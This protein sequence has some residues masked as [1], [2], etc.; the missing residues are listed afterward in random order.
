MGTHAV[1]IAAVMKPDINGLTTME[2][3]IPTT[4][5]ERHSP[6]LKAV[7]RGPKNNSQYGNDR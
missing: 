6:S 3:M 2:S 4:A 5:P 7:K 1:S